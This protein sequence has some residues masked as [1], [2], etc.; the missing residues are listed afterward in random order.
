MGTVP[1]ATLLERK[2][3]LLKL[4]EAEKT[5]S[6][7]TLGL[8]NVLCSDDQEIMN[9]E[10]LLKYLREMQRTGKTIDV[11]EFA[12]AEAEVLH[13]GGSESVD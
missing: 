5:Q 3:K 11:V 4:D 9:V 13:D 12:L 1:N 7:E 2:Y 10:A 6:A 8:G